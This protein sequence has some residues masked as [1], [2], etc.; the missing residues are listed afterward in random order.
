MESFRADDLMTF[1]EV[2]LNVLVAIILCNFFSL[3]W[4][5]FSK[6]QV[7]F[8]EDNLSNYLPD[9]CLPF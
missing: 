7:Y 2:S 8:L 9:N 6:L 5:V 1:Y 4:F 3:E